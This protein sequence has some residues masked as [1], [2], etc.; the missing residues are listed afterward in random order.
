MKNKLPISHRETLQAMVQHLCKVA[1]NSDTNK[2]DLRNL[3]I[4]FGPTLVRTSDDNML[5]MINDM[6][7]QCKIVE[8]ILSNCEWFFK[9][10]S[11]LKALKQ[12]LKGWRPDEWVADPLAKANIDIQTCLF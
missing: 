2:M 5:S 10:D 11:E 1:E 8:S 4:V 6:S 7:H 12:I 3:A 9:D